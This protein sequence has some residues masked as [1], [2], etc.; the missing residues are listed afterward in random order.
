MAELAL[1][2]G[3][4]AVKALVAGASA[5]VLA[6]ASAVVLAEASA[7]VV[8]EASAVV[9]LEASKLEAHQDP[10]EDILEEALVEAPGRTVEAVDSAVAA[11]EE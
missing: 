3:A 7:V 4:W 9:V 2:A 11:V 6:E 8:L 1:V 10:P 5:V